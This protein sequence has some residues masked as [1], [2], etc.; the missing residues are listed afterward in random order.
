[1]GSVPN[2][3]AGQHSGL[4]VIG[5]G[6]VG[7]MMTL[8]FLGECQR[9]SKNGKVAPIEVGKEDEQWGASRWTMAYLRLDKN[10]NFD[11][12][13]IKEMHLVSNGLAD[14]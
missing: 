4:V 1:M 8:N 7:S 5:S 11:L 6:F 13:W 12:D 2:V 10:N 14:L 9:S 3:T